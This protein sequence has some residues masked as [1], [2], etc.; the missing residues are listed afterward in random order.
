MRL[1]AIT[2]FPIKSCRGIDVE[3]AVV[4]RR[5]LRHDRR[6]MIVD[7]AAR[8]VTQREEPALARVAVALEG[9]LLVVAV[10]GHGEA[11][12]DA[13][14]TEAS[15][16]P[17]ARVTVWNS[18][19]DAFEVPM[20]SAFFASF[21]GREV[22]CV[23][24]PESVRRALSP[25]HARPGD[26]VSF[27]DGYP[28]LVANE[29]SRLDLEARAGVPLEMARFRPNLVV[30]GAPA[31][32]EDRWGRIRVGP[33]W[34]RVAKPCARC[35]MTTLDPRTG[36]VGKEPLRTLAAFRRVDGEVTFGLNLVPELDD[37]SPPPT[38]R[39]GDPVACEV[40]RSAT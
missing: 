31:W 16:G 1:A 18:T 32:E 24:M 15:L 36:A 33:L 4:E 35:V 11:R 12:T 25:A 5:G 7:D 3:A 37:C 10:D 2:I 6:F 39:V 38:L 29:G 20:L 40:A 26:V 21:L 27:A 28:L 34:L 8:F 19:V 22:R 13:T 9:S 14:P 17:P 23:Y 30:S